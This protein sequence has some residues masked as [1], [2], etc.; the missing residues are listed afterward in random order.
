MKHAA[1]LFIPFFLFF[2]PLF[3]FADSDSLEY[4]AQLIQN[5]NDLELH[6][7]RYWH[8]LL[9]YEKT[10]LGHYKSEA[11]GQDFFFAKDG[12]NNPKAELQATLKAFFG[13]SILDPEIQHPQCKFIGRYQW[14]KKQLNF[15]QKLLKEQACPRF[16]KWQKALS[17]QSLTVVFASYYLNNPASMF[18]HTLLRIDSKPYEEGQHP[19]LHYA[20]NYAANTGDDGGI[21]FAFLGL[22]GGYPGTFAMFPYYLKVQEYTNLKKRDLWE[23]KLRFSKEQIHRMLEHLWELGSTHF[24]YFFVTENCSYHLL[25]LLEIANPSLDL[26]TKRH[27]FV[28]PAETIK[29]IHKQPGLVESIT[30]RPSLLS[31]MNQKLLL[32]KG[33]EK[34]ALKQFLKGKEE[35]LLHLPP[36]RQALLIDTGV[37]FLDL[38]LE[39]KD[40]ANLRKKLLQKRSQLPDPPKVPNIEMTTPPDL[41]HGSSRVGIGGGVS[42]GD[43]FE[44]FRYRLVLQDV[45]S[46]EDGYLPNSQIQFLDTSLRFYNKT[47]KVRLENIAVVNVLSL[48]PL[49]SMIKRPSWNV[50]LGVNTLRNQSSCVECNAFYFQGGPGLALETKFLT[51]VA[52]YILTNAMVQASPSINGGYRLGP[53][54]LGGILIE[55]HKR[56]KLQVSGY[57]DYAPLGKRS[58]DYGGKLHQ[59]FSILRNLEIRVELNKFKKGEEALGLFYYYF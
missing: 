45:L 50:S 33:K 28:A 10:F 57:Y 56:W 38:D 21:A 53:Q 29:T 11:D 58:D 36:D 6:K 39:K 14:L 47:Q 49:Q 7:N 22:T 23:Y 18:G 32:L 2:F 51:K 30:Y 44:D 24:D 54:V 15:D 34:R 8:L 52:Y 37:N 26:K 20:I 27:L 4:A 12:K 59:R 41:G 31:R 43:S 40:R 48:T 1:F 25:S 13:P 19:L 55:L 9:H 42:N 16:E 5:A 46:P 17:P 35:N 3:T